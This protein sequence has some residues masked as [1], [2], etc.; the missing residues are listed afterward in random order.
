MTARKRKDDR[1]LGARGGIVLLLAFVMVCSTALLVCPA[2]A[3][4]SPK[5]ITLSGWGWCVAYR[6]VGNV[7]LVLDGSSIPRENATDIEDLYLKGTLTFNLEDRSDQFELEL[8]GTRVRSL[9]FLK[10][11]SGGETPLI[12]EFEGSW[13]SETDY[14]VCEGRIVVPAPNHVAKPYFLVLRTK[15]TEMPTRASGTWVADLDFM[16]GK[17]T[18]AADN[19]AE[20]LS[21]G[22]SLIKQN[23]GDLLAKTAF[24]VRELRALGIPY[25][26]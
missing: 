1:L 17:L 18:S 13:L 23:L 11:V 26:T 9:F 10:Q 21:T 6:E 24:I 2:P 8:R 14:V 22:G 7:S 4:A 19:I 12:A 15:D 25:L 3:V 16:I 20:R 5:T